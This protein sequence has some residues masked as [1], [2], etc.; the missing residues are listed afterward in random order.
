MR[1]DRHEISFYEKFEKVL[2]TS[3]KCKNKKM[4]NN[5]ELF[6]TSYLTILYVTF[7]MSLYLSL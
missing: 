2:I 4:S 7:L 6:S 3:N 1:Q 5:I